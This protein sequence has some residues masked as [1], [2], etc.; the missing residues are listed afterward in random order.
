MNS[1][2][3]CARRSLSHIN[4]ISRTPWNPVLKMPKRIFIV[5]GFACAVWAFCGALV[6]IGRQLM[7]MEATLVAHAMGAPVGAAVL[8]WLYFHNFNYTSPV[9]TAA[10]FVCTALALDFLVVAMLIEKSFDMFRSLLG[11]WIPQALIFTAT[12]IT[13]AVTTRTVASSL[14]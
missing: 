12:W 14:R 3:R 13:G 5:V 11:V 1:L 6:G 8:G 4:V 2:W 9:S 10:I 7:S